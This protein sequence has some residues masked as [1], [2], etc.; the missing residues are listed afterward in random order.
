[1]TRLANAR[2]ATSD[3]VTQPAAK[4]L[5]KTPLTPNALTWLGFGITVVAAVL[6][7][8]GNPLAGG[9]VVL[10]AGFFDMLDGALARITDRVTRFGGVLDSAL[11]RISEA[12]VLL[13]IL[14][15]YVRGQQVGGSLLVGFAMLGS[16]MVSYLRA[17]IEGLG[18]EGKEGLF[19]RPERVVVVALGL[20]LSHYEYALITA[21]AVI[22]FFSY[23]TVVQRLLY[24]WRQTR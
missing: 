11:D 24:A 6:V 23:L 8:T 7:A 15:V 13:A 2:K 4:L 20:I 21:L 9:L 16:F 1:M 19:T 14:A 22:V 10:F 12:V 5:A 17:K 3:Y 18:L